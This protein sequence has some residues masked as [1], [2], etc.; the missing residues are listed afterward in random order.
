MIKE[1][2]LRAMMLKRMA[3]VLFS[4]EVNQFKSA[5]PEIQERLADSLKLQHVPNIQQQVLIFHC[6]VL[7]HIKYSVRM[8]FKIISHLF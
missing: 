2:E 4:S 8:F 3:F 5:L 6:N 1:H 7:F